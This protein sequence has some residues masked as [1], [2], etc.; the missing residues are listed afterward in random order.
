MHSGRRHADL[1]RQPH[2]QFG[3]VRIEPAA[4]RLLRDGRE[5]MLEPRVWAVLLHLLSR[6]GEMVSH[7]ALLDAVWGHRHVAPGVLSRCIAQL[8]A[9]LGDPARAPRLV[10][11]VHGQG[12][13]FCGRDGP[14]VGPVPEE[15]AGPGGLSLPGGRFIGRG[16]VLRA[17]WECLGGHRLLVVCGAAG[18]GKSAL[19][20]RLAHRWQARSR[21]P[22][23]WVGAAGVEAVLDGLAG[24]REDGLWVLDG[25][26]RCPA[27]VS[28]CCGRQ[29]R[30]PGRCRMLLTSQLRL[31]VPGGRVCRL[32]PLPVGTDGSTGV[33]QRLLRIGARRQVGAEPVDPG[34]ACA[35]SEALGGLPLALEIAASHLP[36]LGEAG[37]RALVEAAPSSLAWVQPGGVPAHHVSLRALHGYALALAAGDELQ[38]LQGLAKVPGDW[39]LGEALAI[40]GAA[41]GGGDAARVL[42]GLVGKSL[43]ERKDAGVQPRFWMLPTQRD[44]LRSRTP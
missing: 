1:P 6:R 25:V 36:L 18:V 2:L 40:A 24:S 44:Y 10:Q 32:P 7:E 3:G 16:D 43:L 13:R 42:A 28:A 9:G 35:V 38:A 22:V 4:R 14:L 17:A 37:V 33:A 23:H 34:W 41:V 5:V 19:A 31:E 26:E 27:A 8:R 39:S 20:L 15:P 29:L 11:T 12:Y 30:G 21:L